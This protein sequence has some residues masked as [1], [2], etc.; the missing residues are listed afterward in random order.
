[1]AGVYDM[2]HEFENKEFDNY[3]EYFSATW[4][5]SWGRKKS[6]VYKEKLNTASKDKLVDIAMERH[7]K[8]DWAND[9]AYERGLE[10]ETLETTIANN[11]TLH[12]Q[13]LDKHTNNCLILSAVLGFLIV[14]EV[15]SIALRKYKNKIRQET[16]REL[17][18][19]TTIK[20]SK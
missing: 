18:N 4:E 19:D 20:I 11:E 1:M 8:Y 5:E 7:Q 3:N 2:I 13:E 10:I 15:I 17:Q 12:Q 14:C 9:L 16:I 6:D